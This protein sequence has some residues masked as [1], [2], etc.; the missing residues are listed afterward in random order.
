MEQDHGSDA[1]HDG[2]D[3]RWL[4]VRS[5]VDRQ[6]EVFARRRRRDKRKA[7]GLQTATVTLSATVTVLL[8]LRTSDAARTWLLNIALVLGAAITVLAAMEAFFS[9]RRMWV[10]RTVT[11]RRL[12]SLSRQVAFHMADAGTARADAAALSACLAEL[13]AIIADD[14]KAWQHL[15]EA[16]PEAASRRPYD[17][18]EPTAPAVP[19]EQAG[20]E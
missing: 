14:V 6:L 16:P 7:F 10:L 4:F 5:E 18:P 9:H 20:I 3:G 2:Q 13:D 15:H 12:E 8:G 11:V 1:H 19:E 17:A